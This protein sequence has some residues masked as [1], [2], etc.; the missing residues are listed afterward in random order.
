MKS[1]ELS[2]DL[3]CRRASDEICLVGC[4]ERALPAVICVRRAAA[5]AS[6]PR[7]RVCIGWHRGGPDDGVDGGEGSQAKPLKGS[8][9]SLEG[10]PRHPAA[11][12]QM[13]C[14]TETKELGSFTVEGVYGRSL[15][16]VM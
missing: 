12:K 10:G 4:G 3:C 9:S 14:A 13:D 2:F 8:V 15:C 16:V 1:A 11:G 6:A 5:P 7:T